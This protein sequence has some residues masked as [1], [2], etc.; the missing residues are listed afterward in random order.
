MCV[1]LGG[2]TCRPHTLGSRTN[3]SWLALAYQSPTLARPDLPGPEVRPVLTC[4]GLLQPTLARPDQ[5]APRLQRDRAREASKIHAA[6]VSPLALFS[7]LVKT[8]EKHRFHCATRKH[9][10]YRPPIPAI[11]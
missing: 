2:G 1:D 3:L 10:T 8:D 11:A 4:P 9:I 5:S 6:N 7:T